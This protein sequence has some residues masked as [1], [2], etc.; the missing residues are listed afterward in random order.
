MAQKAICDILDN[1]YSI[2]D[3]VKDY[4]VSNLK[5][6][7]NG[8]KHIK[9]FTKQ[10]AKVIT[11]AKATLREHT[12]SKVMEE[13]LALLLTREDLLQIVSSEAEK[14]KK[15]LADLKQAKEQREAAPNHSYSTILKSSLTINPSQRNKT[16]KQNKDDLLIN[17]K[18]K[19]KSS[20]NT[21]KII[22]RKI[23][24]SKLGIGVQRMRHIGSG[25]IAIDLDNKQDIE[26]LEKTIEEN[27]PELHT[28]R[29]RK[30]YP[31]IIIYSV[32]RHIDR[33]DLSNMIYE[34]NSVIN[35]NYGAEELS[36]HFKI[37]FN[38]GN[39]EGQYCNWVVEVTPKLR[40]QL[41]V[42][43]KPNVEWS[44][45]RV[46]DFVPILQCYKCCRYGRSTKS[47]AHETPICSHCAEEHTYRE[48]PNRNNTPKCINFHYEKA[49]KTSDNAWDGSCPVFQHVK[50]NIIDCTYYGS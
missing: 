11:M 40:Q 1:S 41:L 6:R 2:L 13:K 3:E 19:D 18:N 7:Q 32:N 30:R 35:Y 12:F 43:E 24:P 25:E 5:G 16:T 20:D 50:N 21:R 45:C 28:G 46:A 42:A 27:I 8:R 22:Q 15:I 26:K 9:Y 33:N 36:E 10:I 49:N 31:H 29:P 44:R 34:Q 38:V 17:Q 47:C 23:Q 39:R 37:K 14:T 4:C 48:C